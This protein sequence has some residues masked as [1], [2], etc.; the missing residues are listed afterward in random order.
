MTP[1]VYAL[2]HAFARW[3]RARRCAA[4]DDHGRL[5][6][7]W[8]LDPALGDDVMHPCCHPGVQREL[9]AARLYVER[10]RSAAAR[11]AAQRGAA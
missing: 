6:C 10:Q 11:A 5:G 3:P 2:D 9:A 7:P 8:P 1:P 4:V